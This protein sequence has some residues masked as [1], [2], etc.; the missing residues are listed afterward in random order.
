MGRHTPLPP[1]IGM[2]GVARSGKDTVAKILHD[3][4][5]YEIYSFSDILNETLIALNPMVTLNPESADK[6]S[7]DGWTRYANLIEAVGY[8]RAK[9]QPEVRRL[10]Q[11]MGTEVGRTYFGQDVWVEALFRKIDVP[12]AVITNVRFP[13]EY[14]AVKDRGGKVWH[15]SRPGFTPANGHISDT[16]LDGHTFDWAFINDGTVEDLA[17]EVVGV[18]G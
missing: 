3:V 7:L 2:S 12:L 5:G 4:Y 13:N 8:E 16:A 10:L 11:A 14:D 18:L 1:I 9:A 6:M 15:V 17:D